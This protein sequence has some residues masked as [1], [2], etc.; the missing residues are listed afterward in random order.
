MGLQA[1]P[2]A[3]RCETLRNKPIHTLAIVGTVRAIDL[4]MNTTITTA[5][6]L[7]NI[8]RF[9]IPGKMHAASR[10]SILAAFASDG[11][12]GIL[13]ATQA[14]SWARGQGDSIYGMALHNHIDFVR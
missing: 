10:A 14:I 1:V 6:E 2:T 9:V 8:L 13:A 5:T 7:K 4:P 11:I 3:A 12:D